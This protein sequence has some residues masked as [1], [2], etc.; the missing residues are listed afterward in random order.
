MINKCFHVNPVSKEQRTF[1]L[2]NSR[3]AIFRF[4]DKFGNT[5]FLTSRQIFSLVGGS[6][7]HLLRRLRLL[8]HHGYLDRPRAQIEYYHLGGSQALVYGLGNRGALEL[9]DRF[10]IPRRKVDW[11]AK[12][13]EATRLFLRHTLFIAD[14]MIAIE[15]SCRK[16]GKV[17]LIS[18]DK[19]L[20]QIPGK[21]RN[22]DEPFRWR[23]NFTDKRKTFSLGVI[24]DK[25]FAL[26]SIQNPEIIAY[27]FLEA[28]RATMP[29]T[30]KS[31]NQTSFHRKLIAY[32][33]TWR[34]N[35]HKTR[36]GFNRFRVLTVTSSAKRVENISSISRELK[37]GHGLFLFADRELFN[38]CRDPFLLE[39]RTYRQ[40][41]RT[42]LFDSPESKVGGR[43]SCTI[44]QT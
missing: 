7:Q 29:V 5:V 38:K 33:E 6:S 24:P 11:T 35:I 23:V 25:V 2:F 9:E 44:Q 8:F 16:S 27:Y 34:Q 32:S 37:Y 10:S 28:D 40:E 17:R 19:L 26:Q 42:S 12:N 20:T 18:L 15:L 43:P 30:R 41:E 39:W 21:A 22:E 14:V 4:F 13:R 1:R 3:C 36:F 31:L